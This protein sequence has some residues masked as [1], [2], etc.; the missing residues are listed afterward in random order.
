MDPDD[1]MTHIE[2][3]ISKIQKSLENIEQTLRGDGGLVVQV[4]VLKNRQDRQDRMMTV[5]ISSSVSAILM[6]LGGAVL[7]VIQRGLIK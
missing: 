5:A 1:R 2:S 6:V 3:D 7:F 4:A